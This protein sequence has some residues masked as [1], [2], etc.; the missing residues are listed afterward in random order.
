MPFTAALSQQSQFNILHCYCKDDFETALIC[1]N[2]RH[3]ARCGENRFESFR[4][5]NANRN[6]QND[7]LTTDTTIAYL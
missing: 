4:T 2:V 3:C 6:H 1:I 7:V 5:A